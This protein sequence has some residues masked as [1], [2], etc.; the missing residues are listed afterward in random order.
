MDYSDYIIYVDESGDSNLHSIDRNY[1]IFVL[2]FC[3]FNKT[4]YNTFVVREFQAF[5][6]RY[7][8]H[9]NVILYG[10]DIVNQKKVFK[11]LQSEQKR[12]CFMNEFIQLMQDI[13][14]S[15]VG[16]VIKKSEF[17]EQY[18]TPWHPDF[19]ALRFCMERAYMFLRDV[20]QHNKTTHIIV[21]KRG[22]KGDNELELAFQRIRAGDNQV[23][24]M[25]N[26]EIEFADK[27]VNSVGLQ[28][29]NFTAYPIGRHV[30]NPE[31]PNRSWD[32]IKD[33]IHHDANGKMMGVG[34]KVF[35]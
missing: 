4:H 10:R 23:A 11:F 17:V 18:K 13:K 35:S 30:I 21:E 34:L 5:K 15:V 6:L 1:P 2:D 12:T 14:V 29:A 28:L 31:Q 25:P 16:A 33:K 32:I 20:N 7:F 3:I 22:K 8:G 27:K 19:I 24:A 9:D 26:F